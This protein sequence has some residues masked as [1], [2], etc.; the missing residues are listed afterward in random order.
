MESRTTLFNPAYIKEQLKGGASS[1]TVFTELIRNTYGWNVMKPKAIDNEM[2]N[3]IYDV[4]VEDNLKLGT[5]AFFEE[6]SPAAL[7]EITAIMMETA[8]KGY[9][10][11]SAGQLKK[12]ASLHS[13]LVRKYDACCNGFTCDNAKLKSF[14]SGQ[15]PEQQAKEYKAEVDNVRQAELPGDNKGVVLQKERNNLPAEQ[16]AGFTGTRAA[17]IAF[18]VVCVAIGFV[19]IVRKR[20]RNG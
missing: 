13:E 4:Y 17:L 20:R 18:A 2:W 3:K 6:E 5:Q 1:A 15:L 10:K 9:W 11:A 7:Q 12:I 19:F 8:R 16:K 14:I